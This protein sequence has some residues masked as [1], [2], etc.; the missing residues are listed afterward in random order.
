MK[1]QF[2]PKTWYHMTVCHSTGSSLSIASATARVY[3]NGVLEASV[4][5]KYPAKMEAVQEVTIGAG[6]SSHPGWTHCCSLVMHVAYHLCGGRAPHKK[7]S[8]CNTY[9]GEAWSLMLCKGNVWSLIAL[10]R[11]HMQMQ[12][13]L[14]SCVCICVRL[15]QHCLMSRVCLC[16]CVRVLQPWMLPAAAS[17]SQCQLSMVR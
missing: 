14:M 16:V 11:C 4:K 15:L 13:Y 8:L 7:A 2:E 9:P 3:I 17:T 5:L 1:F 6:R 12:P 10:T